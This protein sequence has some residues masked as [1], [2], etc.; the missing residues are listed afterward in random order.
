MYEYVPLHSS[1]RVGP[2]V[3]FSMAQVLAQYATTTTHHQWH[4]DISKAR[5]EQN[6]TFTVKGTSSSIQ[7]SAPHEYLLQ[8]GVT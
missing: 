1:F 4:S 8:V 2:L 6:S 3:N 7:D 5:D